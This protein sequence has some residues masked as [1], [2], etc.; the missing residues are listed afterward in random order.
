MQDLIEEVAGAAGL[1]QYEVSAYAR[2]GQRCR[3]NLNYWKFGDYV[4]IGAGAHGK[5]SSLETGTILRTQRLK[6]PMSYLK[7]AEEQ[8][9]LGH[10]SPVVSEEIPFEFLMN[11]LRLREGFEI[12]HFEERTGL[13][14]ETLEPTLTHLLNEQLLERTRTHLR[15][16]EHGFNFLDSILQ[17]FLPT[18]C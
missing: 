15:C 17:H 7:A 3:H 10:A 11:G 1:Q 12:G 16:S 14:M 6:Q 4:G 9:P 8:G 18:P 2:Q 13:A 5:I